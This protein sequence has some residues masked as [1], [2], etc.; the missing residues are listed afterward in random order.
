MTSKIT[1]NLTSIIWEYQ[2]SMAGQMVAKSME[3]AQTKVEKSSAKRKKKVGK[4]SAK[5]SQMIGKIEAKM[6]LHCWL[7]VGPTSPQH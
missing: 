1:F 6:T 4:R 7:N 2:Q 3:K 5:I